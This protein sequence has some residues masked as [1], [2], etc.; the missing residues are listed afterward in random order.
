MSWLKFFGLSRTEQD[1]K[2]KQ[3]V[4]NSYDSVRVVGRGTV[5]IDPQE[6]G[7]SE[8]FKAARKKAKKIVRAA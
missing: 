1:E 4:D 7:N 5:K 3:L 6:V 2:L 8:A